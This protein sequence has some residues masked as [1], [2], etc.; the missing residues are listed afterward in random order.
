MTFENPWG[1]LILKCDKLQRCLNSFKQRL[2]NAVMVRE[3]IFSLA[4]KLL[5]RAAEKQNW[6]RRVMRETVCGQRSF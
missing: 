5:G 3:L 6:R 4:R 1:I 2:L